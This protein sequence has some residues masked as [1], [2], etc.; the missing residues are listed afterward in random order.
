[1]RARALLAL[2]FAAAG[3]AACGGGAAEAPDGGASA[4]NG[5]C[6]PVLA[7]DYDQSCVADTDC[8]SVGEVPTCPASACDGCLLQGINKGAMAPYAAALA[9]AFASAPPGQRCGCP[10][11]GVGALCRG[12]KCQAARC[13]TP[14]E[15]TLPACMAAGGTCGYVS[16]T[17][18][19]RTGPPEGC[20]F[21]D[22]LC[23]LD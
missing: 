13:G 4:S 10:C 5:A 11:E 14:P 20:A 3:A 12:G 2:A 21:T 7:S 9:Q 8:V 23:C 18:C 22:E 15:D 16:N 17:I 6:M 19:H 1:M